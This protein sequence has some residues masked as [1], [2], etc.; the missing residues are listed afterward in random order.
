MNFYCI[1]YD[2]RNEAGYRKL[3]EDFDSTIGREYLKA[4]HINDSQGGYDYI[5][6][7]SLQ[8]P[9]KCQTA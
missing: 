6:S 8:D 9:F 1:G 2:L 4:V 7:V 3:M 5:L